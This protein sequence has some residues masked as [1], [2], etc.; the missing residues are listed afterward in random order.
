MTINRHTLPKIAEAL[1]A[2]NIIRNTV[3]ENN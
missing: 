1:D 3:N 2:L